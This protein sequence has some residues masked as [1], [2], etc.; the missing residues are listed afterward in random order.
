MFSFKEN[1]TKN[2][3]VLFFNFFFEIYCFYDLILFLPIFVLI[4]GSKTGCRCVFF[5]F[6]YGNR[7]LNVEKGIEN[8]RR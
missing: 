4:L 3:F 1:Y 2:D 8:Y 5:G 7:G 6:K